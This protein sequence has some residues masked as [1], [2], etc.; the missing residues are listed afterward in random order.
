MRIEWASGTLAQLPNYESGGLYAR[1]QLV[2]EAAAPAAPAALE[3]KTT[4]FVGAAVRML[5]FSCTL[6]L[7]KG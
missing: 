3:S 2:A 7:L 4:V 5:L 6:F 1:N